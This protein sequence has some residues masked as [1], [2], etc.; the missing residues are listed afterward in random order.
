MSTPETGYAQL[1]RELFP[2]TS[3]RY[4][5]GVD[6]NKAAKAYG[7]SPTTVRRWILGT[8][9][10][11]PK[12]ERRLSRQARRTGVELPTPRRHTPPATPNPAARAREH[13]FR[14]FTGIKDANPNATGTDFNGMLRA[15]YATTDPRSKHGVDVARAAK[16]LEVSE[17]TVRR[18]IR[19]VQAPTEAHEKKLRQRARQMS[20]TKRGRQAIIKAH[21]HDLKET[22]TNKAR[23]SISGLQ[24]PPTRDAAKATDAYLRD[25]VTT[26][27]LSWEEYGQLMDAYATGGDD[28]AQAYLRQGLINRGYPTDWEFSEI[29]GVGLG[30]SDSPRVT[31]WF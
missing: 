2:T 29:N 26:V 21:R 15:A 14:A 7:T 9:E 30:T 13:F 24:G 19:G 8:Q 5:H 11:A 18:W 12:Q 22:S 20:N 17:T 27:D 31:R 23:I 28:A 10:P 4:K 1:L 6:V 16:A 3:G 25:R